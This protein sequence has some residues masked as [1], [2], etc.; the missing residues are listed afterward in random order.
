MESNEV[1]RARYSE[2]AWA[3]SKQQALLNAMMARLQELQTQLDSIVYP[4]LSLPPEITS[5]IFLHCT[6][7][8]YRDAVDTRFAP[9]LLMRV[10]RAWRQ[11][12]ISTPALWTTFHVTRAIRSMP[13][14]AKVWFERARQLPLSV[15]LDQSVLPPGRVIDEFLATFRRHCQSIHSLEL[16]TSGD[17]FQRINTYLLDFIHLLDFTRLRNLSLH[18][19]LGED[20]VFDFPAIEINM[21]H[22]APLLNEVFLGGIPP[23][24]IPLPWQQLTKFTGHFF[25]LPACLYVL[26]RTPN[27]TECALAAYSSHDPEAFD[28]C[29]HPAVE[30]FTLSAAV[31]YY[32]CADSAQVLA[33][34][35]LPAL[36]TLRIDNVDDFDEETFHSFLLRSIAPLKT[37]SIRS[38]RGIIRLLPTQA[39]LRLTDLEISYP[40]NEFLATFF[41]SLAQFPSFLPQLQTLAFPT[42]YRDATVLGSIPKMVRVGATAITAR[43]NLQGCAQLQSFR[44][45]S[46]FHDAPA[47]VPLLSKRDLQLFRNLKA[48]GMDIH[49][50]SE[51]ESLV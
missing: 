16:H 31:N 15:S 47:F 37:L 13:E 1:L 42:G 6:P 36:H 2:L 14:I 8:G 38:R 27:V 40:T 17:G 24:L 32:D 39:M 10:C 50:G 25:T 19:L 7:E 49:I 18:L 45:T 33:F 9:L 41:E 23:S 46:D 51:W 28:I 44:V 35:T 11:V 4:V 43:R 22:S 21:F 30:T 48:S 12:A 34:I 20:E 3:I 29:R 5:E 26:R